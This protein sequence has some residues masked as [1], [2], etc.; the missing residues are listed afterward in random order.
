MCECLKGRLIAPAL[1]EDHHDRTAAHNHLAGRFCGQRWPG[2]KGFIDRGH[3][4][5]LSTARRERPPPAHGA[6]R[7]TIATRSAEPPNCPLLGRPMRT[8]QASASGRTR[9]NHRRSQF[10][11][12]LPIVGERSGRWR[13]SLAARSDPSRHWL[14]PRIAAPRERLPRFP[15]WHRRRLRKPVTIRRMH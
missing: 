9:S 15:I 6:L 11:P 4:A 3:R 8:E 14:Q 12:L 1:H 2:T 5:A 10:D 13:P 7:S